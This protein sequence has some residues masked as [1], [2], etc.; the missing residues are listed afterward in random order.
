WYFQMQQY[1][2]AVDVFQRASAACRN[3]QSS[4]AKPLARSLL[5]SYRPAE[6]QRLLNAY[7]PAANNA[8]WL[9]LKADAGF[10]PGALKNAWK[11]S[12]VN[13]G[14]RVNTPDPEMYPNITSDTQNIYFTRRLN[15]VDQDFYFA[16][17][18]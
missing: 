3:G 1:D 9:K 17:I 8:D 11:D 14:Q 18:D 10:M 5:A 6:A 16:T 15:N 13:L 2:K 7:M 12:A 4:F